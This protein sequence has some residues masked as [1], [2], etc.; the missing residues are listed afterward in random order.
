ML[1]SLDLISVLVASARLTED[2]GVAP[3]I[4]IV[5]VRSKANADGHVT[6]E[7]DH[8]IIQEGIEVVRE[9]EIAIEEPGDCLNIFLIWNLQV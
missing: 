4:E 6:E 2:A 1:S 8:V 3:V 9:I 5:T 7:V